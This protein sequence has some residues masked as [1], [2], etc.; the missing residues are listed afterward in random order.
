MAASPELVAATTEL[1]P[2]VVAILT[3]ASIDVPK[4]VAAA[5]A[6]AARDVSFTKSAAVQRLS[7]A[8]VRL[9]VYGRIDLAVALART[10]AA[11]PFTGNVTLYEPI[12]QS[13]HV[14]RLFAQRAGDAAAVAV[15]DASV[16]IPAGWSPLP[17]RLDGALLKRLQEQPERWERARDVDRASALLYDVTELATM[18]TFG[19]SSAWPPARIL[20][21][22]DASI[23]LLDS[24]PGFARA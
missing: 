4:P 14:A 15:L 17:N 16:S 24:V 23:D 7:E 20:E 2:A 9:S 6:K 8:T 22:I 12:R 3:D 5:L 18:A 13:V 10:V 11:V 19:G 1:A 21:Q